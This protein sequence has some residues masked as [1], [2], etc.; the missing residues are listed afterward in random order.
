VIVGA[1]GWLSKK[2]EYEKLFTNTHN[3]GIWSG[4]FSLGVNLYWQMLKNAMQVIQQFENEYD[5]MIHEFHH[6]N[7]MDSPSGTALQIADIV[8]KNS[9]VKTE[10]VTETLN[11][12]RL[13]N[14]LHVS[15]T[16]GG[17]IPGTHSV[18]FDSNFD[19][20]ELTHIARTRDGFALGSVLAAE[21]I[22]KLKPGL[23]Q[24]SDVFSTIFS[25]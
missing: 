20:I 18:I 2:E 4:N 19:T 24:F 14:E 22:K 16:R 10:I 11:R 15:S 6:K 17:A 21:Q 5:V 1:T 12:K 7:K 8:V 25:K 9:S 13:D 3:I 23:H